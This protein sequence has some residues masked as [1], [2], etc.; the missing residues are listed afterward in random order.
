MLY[1]LPKHADLYL[2]GKPVGR[3]EMSRF[4]DSWHFGS[5]QPERAFSEF[6]ALFGEWSLLLHADE[7]EAKA[8][9]EA[10]EEL[11]KIEMAIDALRAELVL[12]ETEQHLA[13]NQLNI[14]GDMI[15]LKLA[16]QPV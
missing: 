8:S 13:I 5:F 3:V 12:P 6:A 16:E 1:Q 7:N 11:S 14:D 9:R 4:A 10:L 15:E 2:Q